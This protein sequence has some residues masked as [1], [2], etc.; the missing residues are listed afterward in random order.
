MAVFVNGSALGRRIDRCALRQTGRVALLVLGL[1]ERELS[2]TLVPDSRIAELAGRFGRAPRPTDVL[3]FPVDEGPSAGFGDECLGD[4][5][6]S[7]ETAERQAR[8]RGCDLDRELRDLA[9]HGILHLAGMDHHRAHDTRRMRE[10]EE[11]L[12]WEI[13]RSC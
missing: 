7:I 8:E 13:E 1:E 9:L 11:Q 3:A 12:R 10:L 5:V 6:I 4:V 2:I